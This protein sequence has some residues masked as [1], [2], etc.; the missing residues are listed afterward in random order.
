MIDIKKIAKSA[1]NK[2][3]MKHNIDLSECMKCKHADIRY[4]YKVHVT[5]TI[6]GDSVDDDNYDCPARD[7]SY[8][9]CEK[10]RTYCHKDFTCDKC[11][12]E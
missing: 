12:F 7:L 5:C 9:L 10:Y 6:L 2:R 8:R 11:P 4:G 3:V 1:V